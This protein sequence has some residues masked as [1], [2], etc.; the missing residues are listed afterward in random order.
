[1]SL[2]RRSLM[3][4]S[5]FWKYIY[6]IDPVVERYFVEKYDKDGDGRLSIKEAAAIQTI[7]TLPEGAT[8]FRELDR[9]PNS[10]AS[11]LMPSTMREVV[12]PPR[13]TKLINSIGFSA[14]SSDK[15]VF[16]LL[17]NITEIGFR[18]LGGYGSG[19]HYIVLL[20]NTIDPPLTAGQSFGAYVT[21][22][23]IYVPDNSVRKYKDKW[24]YQG[25][26]DGFS[27]FSIDKIKPISEYYE[28]KK[29]GYEF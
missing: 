2:Y 7:G 22:D 9:M 17:G 11:L 1:M 13:F 6:F 18:A 12:I 16:N 5:Y 15:A 24:M 14:Y 19:R 4:S 27:G 23:A 21:V 10:D 29:K 3:Q 25:N 28:L 20:P 8:Y 26:I